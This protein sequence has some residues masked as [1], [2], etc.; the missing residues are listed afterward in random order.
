MKKSIIAVTLATLLTAC[1]GSGKKQ[2]TPNNGNNANAGKFDFVATQ[3]ITNL[4]DN[5]IV[6]GYKELADKAKALHLATETLV[7]TP[8][9][10]NLKAAQDA[11]KAARKPWEQGESHI[12]GPVDALGVDPKVDTW[13]LDTNGVKTIISNGNFTAETIKN[14][15]EDQQGFHAMEYVLFGDGKADNVKN[16]AELSQN[17]RDFIKEVADVFLS[18]TNELRDAWIENYNKSPDGKKEAFANQLKSPGDNS[19]YA[20]QLA[21]I[22][23][24]VEGMKGIVDEVGNG[25]IA[26][27]YEKKDVTKVESQYSWNSLTDFGNNI[28]GVKNVWEG[29]FTNGQDKQGIVDFVKAGNPALATR[30]STEIDT[31]ITKIRDID[32]GE[33]MPFR[34][35][36]SDTA[37]RVRI[38]AAIES[39]SKLH[40]SL[41]NDVTPL[42]KKWNAQ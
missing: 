17:E 5:V 6:E 19:K 21:V 24:L 8:T 27:P 35:A 15:N 14:L 3:M 18:Y 37:G 32:G 39:L 40:A 2:E 7:N 25:K 12:F 33:G 11:W 16:I 22:Q 34:Q 31:A 29:E 42:I 10:E 36:I 26:E 9:Q 41:H 28:K 23:E 30:I 1:G 4:T 13:P 20:S 38:Q